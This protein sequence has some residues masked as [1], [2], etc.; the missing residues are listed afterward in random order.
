MRRWG[1]AAL[2]LFLST[3]LGSGAIA[4]TELALTVD[5][6]PTHGA[7]PP[8]ATR[9]AIADQMIQA[10]KRHAAPGVYGFMNGGQLPNDPE[11]EEILRAWRQAGFVLGNH[12][13][14]HLDLTF[15]YP[16]LRE[17]NTREKRTAVREWLTARGYTIAQVTVSVEDDWAWN[18]VYARCASFNDQPAIARLKSLFLERSTSRLAA[19][20]ELSR[21]LFGRSIKHILMVHISAFDALMLDDLLTAYRAAGT[22]FIS[23]Q[24]ATQDPA[25]RVIRAPFQDGGATFLV[26]IARDR[27]VPL[28]EALTR[29]REEV[30]RLC[31]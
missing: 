8:G 14:S 11:L 29:S 13:Y 17:G 7:L 12:T 6:L 16:Y 25:Y 20:E 28:P 22:R 21:R 26:Q 30:T 23:L 4:G 3:A 15:R 19:F 1:V 10:L 31:R 9:L 5:D 2:A 27:R 18:D 24:E